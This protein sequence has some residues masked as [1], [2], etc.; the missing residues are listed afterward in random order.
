MT[1]SN[2]QRT[3]AQF[4]KYLLVGGI[5][6]LVTLAVIALCKSVLSI[7][8]MASN[9]IGY[10]AGVINS[11]IWNRSWVFRSGGRLTG[12]AI[13]FLVGFGLCYGIQFAIVYAT[14]RFTD[15]AH[16]VWHAGPVAISGYG[17]VTIAAM[18]V[19]TVC[20]FVYNKF[21]SFKN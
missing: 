2:N 15:A 10:A 11:F 9:A 13:K 18:G 3:A 6:T 1:D 5:N 21:I 19:Y 4:V 20:N 14:M 8:P 12:Q 17:M 7:S 16:T